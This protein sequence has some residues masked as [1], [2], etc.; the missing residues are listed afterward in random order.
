MLDLPLI[1]IVIPLYNKK[2]T[3]ERCIK[4]VLYQNYSNIEIIVVDDGSTD[5]SGELAYGMKN[6]KIIYLRKENGG[7]SSAR[8]Y[9]VKFAHGEW[10]I[11]LDADDYLL[12]FCITNLYKTSVKYKVKFVTG[13]YYIKNGNEFRKFSPFKYSGRIKNNF[14]SFVLRFYVGRTGT[15]LYHKT[16]CNEHPFRENLS[17]YEDDEVLA[18]VLRTYKIA[19]TSVPIMV[20]TVEYRELSLRKSDI[21]KDYI[22]CIDFENSTMGERIYNYRILSGAWNHYKDKTEF[23][24]ERYGKYKL[25]IVCIHYFMFLLNSIY[26]LV[27][28]SV[29]LNE[30]HDLYTE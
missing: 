11:F 18:Y 5:G 4:S 16:I 6:D 29:S 15:M 23:L 14:L 22:S 28:R 30:I 13:N 20:S 17:R 26:K 9:G 2:Y 27:N 10:I 12:P 1:S 21:M 24:N 8:N 3:I 25:K 7:V 19:Y